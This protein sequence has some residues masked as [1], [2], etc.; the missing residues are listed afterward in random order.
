MAL[1]CGHV[2][3]LEYLDRHV[4]VHDV[5]AIGDQGSISSL[6]LSKISEKAPRCPTCLAPIKDVRRYS[7]LMQLKSL[8]DNVDRMIAKMGRKLYMFEEQLSCTERELEAEFARFC[9]KIR[10]TPMAAKVNQRMVWERG[11]LLMEVQNRV[12]KF[13]GR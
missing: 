6:S 8:S 12:T 4:R 1:N 13:R 3:D 2:F 5:Y 9:N 10:T 7:Y 11:N